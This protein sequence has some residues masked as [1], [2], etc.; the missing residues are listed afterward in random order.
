ML[1]ENTNIIVDGFIFGKKNKQNR[2]I[3]FLT[4]MHADHY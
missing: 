3:Y 1:I 2:F 4:H